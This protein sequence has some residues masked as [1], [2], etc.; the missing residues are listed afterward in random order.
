MTSP[1]PDP[2]TA[3]LSSALLERHFPEDARAAV[4]RAAAARNPGYDLDKLHHMLPW[5]VARYERPQLPALVGILEDRAAFSRS[6]GLRV[7]D[8]AIRMPGLGWAIP[9][10]FEQFEEVIRLA[11]AFERSIN[12]GFDE[13]YYAYFTVD[14]KRVEP[15]PARSTTSTRR[16]SRT[17]PTSSSTRSRRCSCQGPSRSAA[18]TRPTSPGC[19]P[20]STSWPRGTSRG[21]IRLITCCG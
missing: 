5:D 4:R 16:S 9:R 18:W 14:Q 1:E 6:R 21:D 17:T 3:G 7:L 11:V 20:A 19:S 13:H 8:L 10:A 15:R 2:F 12:P